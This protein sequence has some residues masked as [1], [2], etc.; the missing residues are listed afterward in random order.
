LAGVGPGL[1]PVHATRSRD[2]VTP[3]RYV[4]VDAKNGLG[5][6]L[7][8]LASAMA[9][10]AAL[11]RPLM[12][13]WVADLHC[14]CSFRNM[15]APPLKFAVLEEEL[16]RANLTD[17]LF[18]VYNYMRPEP[19]AVKDAQ[20]EPDAQKHLYFKSAFLMNHP[21]GIWRAA[22]P[23]VEKLTPVAE[24]ASKLVADKGM[25]GLHV[26]NVFDAPRDDATAKVTLGEDAV[27]EAQKEYGTE[28]ARQLMQWRK[29]SHW[30]NF[31]PRIVALLQEHAYQHPQGLAQEPLH[32]YLAA[33]SK[34]AYEGLSKRFPGRMLFTQRQCATERCDFRDCTGMRYSLID[35]MNLARTRLVLGSGER[36][37]RP[38][39]LRLRLRLRAARCSVGLAACPLRARRCPS[40]PRLPRLTAAPVPRG[41]RL[42][43]VFRGGGLLGRR[44]RQ[45]GADAHGWAG[46]WPAGRHADT[47]CGARRGSE[48]IGARLRVRA[49]LG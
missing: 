17:D 5:N 20:V 10:A 22:Q 47:C 49:E 42:E 13:V 38:P 16:P 23:Q 35:M 45:A 34:E 3:L 32:F 26:R 33:D 48:E 8:A 43:L 7:R 2:H 40:C 44:G 18:Q 9:V 21:A 29:A 12:L 31:V 27:R 14:N 15:F 24:V 1:Q 4:I 46:L 28:G 39:R 19:G 6:R 30:T 41:S 36:P 25:I 37:P 11:E